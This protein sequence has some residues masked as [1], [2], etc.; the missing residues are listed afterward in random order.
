MALSARTALRPV[1]SPAPARAAPPRRAAT[2]IMAASFHDFKAKDLSGA[3]VSFDQYKGKVVLV[4]NVACQCGLT[5]SNYKELVALHQQYADQGLVI[6]AWPSN[7]F[8]AQEPGTPE[9]IRTFVNTKFGGDGLTLMEKV[10]VNGPRTH[11]VWQ[12]LKAE[13]APEEVRW[14]FGAKFLIAKDGTVVERNGDNPR[15]SEAKIKELL[16]A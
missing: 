5:S 4:T 3:E 11:P 14:N 13:T 6:Q 12:F 2:K 10:D 16:A 9:E 8:G 7:Q 1:F 15:A